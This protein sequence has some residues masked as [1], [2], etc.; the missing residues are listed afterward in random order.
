MCPVQKWSLFGAG[1]YFLLVREDEQSNRSADEDENSS[2]FVF[3]LGTL[4]FKLSCSFYY[5][6]DI[7]VV[8]NE[9]NLLEVIKNRPI[10]R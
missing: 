10:P 2:T 8:Q 9:V 4:V 3:C 6:S 1:K 7:S 5:A